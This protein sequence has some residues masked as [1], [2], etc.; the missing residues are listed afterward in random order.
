MPHLVIQTALGPVTVLV[1]RDEKVRRPFEFREQGYAGTIEP[2][3]AGSIAVIGRSPVQARRVA[4]QVMAA[5]D[6]L[7]RP[8]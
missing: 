1:M 8:L 5:L 4:T 3:G 2:A 6:L 7:P